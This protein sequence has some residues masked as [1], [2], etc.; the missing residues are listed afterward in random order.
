MVEFTPATRADAI[1]LARNLRE[2]DRVELWAA[3]RD[4]P[5]DAIL[6][7]IGGPGWA[8]TARRN[9]V[10]ALIFGVAPAGS[11]LDPRGVPWMLGTPLVSAH[12]R[13]FMRLSAPYIARMLREYPHLLNA[14]HAPNKQAVGWLRHMGFVLQ[15]AVP[16]GPRGE[17]FHLFEKR[18]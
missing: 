7:G 16:M 5:L 9:G 8:L 1:E 3:G 6:A 10:L 11:I 13:V 14:V 4:D 17:L 18:A 12:A 2:A 15:P